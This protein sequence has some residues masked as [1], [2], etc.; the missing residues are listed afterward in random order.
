M[1][2]HGSVL[3]RTLSVQ[4]IGGRDAQDT[5]GM[6]LRGV[7]RS[8]SAR[9]LLRCESGQV[10]ALTALSMTAL[11]GAMALA[12]DVG[13]LHY[14]QC[15]LQTA[16]DSAAI[17]AGLELGNCGNTVC[18][19]METAAAVALQESGISS[20]SITPVINQCAVSKSSSLAMI[21]NV[22]PCMLGASDPNNGNANMAEVVLTEQQSTF[23]GAIFGIR[24]VNLVARA[25]AGEAYIN[26]APTP[27]ACLYAKSL[28][29][30][31][32]AS[33]DLQNCGIY[34]YGNLQTNTNESTIATDFLYY[35]TWSPNNCHKNC[36][37][38]LGE[39]ETQPTHT[40]TA[41]P[42]PLASQYSTPPSK[43]G[44]TYTN[45]TFNSN[46][47]PNTLNP[48][49]YQGDVNINSNVT[50]NLTPG[51]YY[52][53]GSLNV[54]SNSTLECTTCTGGQGVTLYFNT[55][56]L[57][58]NSNSTVQLTAATAGSQTNGAYPNML[59]WGGPSAANME[60]DSN[61]NSYFN[62]IIY[63]PDQTL[64]LN[65]NSSV[66]VNG[67][68]VSTA[69]DVNNLM[70]DSNESF[71]LNGSN[72]LLGS[73]GNPPTLGAFALAE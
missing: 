71:V 35:G 34:D 10:L 27:P 24:T 17:A 12:I 6:N 47:G 48:G 9:G 11:M 56:Q 58:A 59:L 38:T 28:E 1:N 68:A 46:S 16:A 64:T 54:D 52:F 51:L 62:G 44:T 67:T 33:L 14:R 55:G 63:L 4:H 50:V 8:G 22:A 5:S 30:N 42:D 19:N 49:Y 73:S 18:A 41:T 69:L 32:N 60:I 72:A 20:N 15:L 65:S 2:A 37:W 26:S 61:S 7:A 57:Q 45:V 3:E 70:L 39:G 53:D 23:F 31:S 66:N 43:P 21:I 40:T 13:Q 36:T 25:E 29:F